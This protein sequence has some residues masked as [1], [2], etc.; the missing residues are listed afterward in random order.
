MEYITVEQAAA[1]LG[2]TAWGIRDRIQRGA[3][4]AERLGKRVWAIPREEVER[5]KQLGRQRP[6]PKPK[7]KTR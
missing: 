4:R 3:M 5:W 7:K 6:G 2:L 1:E